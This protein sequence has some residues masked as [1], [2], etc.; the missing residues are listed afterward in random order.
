MN[1]LW[2]LA[3]S[4]FGKSSLNKVK[5]EE[6][7]WQ[8]YQLSNLPLTSTRRLI[9]FQQFVDAGS[10]KSKADDGQRAREKNLAHPEET[11]WR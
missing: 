6:N 7:E 3:I 4:V 11:A 9:V 10:V 2:L 8:K 5:R 1:S